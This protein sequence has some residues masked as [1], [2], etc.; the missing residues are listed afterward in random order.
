MH[1][2]VLTDRFT[3][4]ISA[5]SVRIMEHARCWKEL[6]HEVTVVTCAPNF[7]HGKL[8]PGYKNRF[9]QIEWMEGI[10][11]IR[12]WSYLA[13]NSGTLKRL[14]DYNSFL[15]SSLFFAWRYP[16]F[17][18]L[19]ATSP[20]LF[21]ALAG[22]LI[23]KI[24]RRPWIFEIRDLWPMSVRA[25]GMNVGRFLKTFE[26][27]ELFLYRRANRIISVSPAF[28]N[29]LVGLGISKEKLEVVTNGVDTEFFSGKHVRFNARERLGIRSTD[30]LCGYIG[31]VGMAH[32]LKTILDA[33]EKTRESDDLY[34]LIM[35]EGA[36]REALEKEARNRGLVRV[37]F[38]DFVPHEDVPS[39]LASL[40]VSIVHLKPDPVFKSV[41]P[42][43]IFECMAMGVQILCAVEGIAADIV[44][45]MRA[46]ICI[47]PGD[48]QK[49]AD[50]VMQLKKERGSRDYVPAEA[51][52][53]V[54]Q[55]Y[56]RRAKAEQMLLCF[57]RTL[58][59]ATRAVQGGIIKNSSQTL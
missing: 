44:N 2:L 55:H 29:Y 50:A 47:P 31:T 7:P 26:R 36:E 34:F 6:G 57:D 53:A 17:D 15:F 11:V 41:I 35:G 24:R 23:A 14:I 54:A 16:T 58:G 39:Y 38:H 59:T 9:Y 5:P 33:A 42:S 10:R 48:S 40:D 3:P 8:F 51:Q 45:E 12:V 32:G 46:G 21:V 49:M 19:L 56:S 28:L 13:A 22:F 37:L 43:K 18:I 30:Y 52:I 4:E 27:L 25:V 1:I 20:P